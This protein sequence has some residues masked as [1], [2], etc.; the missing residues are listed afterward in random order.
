[1][2]KNIAIVIPSCDNYSD[3]WEVLGQAY[4]RFWADCPYKRYVITNGKT[5][6]N[7][8]IGVD[9]GTDVDWSTNFLNVL[10]RIPEDYILIHIDDLIF[11][12][13]IDSNFIK[14]CIDSFIHKNWNYLKLL[15]MWKKSK[16]LL[17]PYANKDM[18]RASTVFSLWKKSV[19][20]STLKAGENP[21]Q[22]EI[23]WAERTFDKKGRYYT[24]KD[25]FGFQ[26][27]VIKRKIERLALLKLKKSGLTYSPKRVKM[28]LCENLL[29]WLK[30][31]VYNIFFL[32]PNAI[33]SF[34]IKLARKLW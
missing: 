31:G 9:I 26:N 30:A 11:D 28:S 8:F 5:V 14:S 10:V 6:S 2:E 1:M 32:F 7:Q 20:I 13:K 21:W 34:L 23:N 18:G 27:L 4:R 3:M 12:K 25:C 24:C 17:L 16:E 33:S 22:F 29:H 15:N 19:L